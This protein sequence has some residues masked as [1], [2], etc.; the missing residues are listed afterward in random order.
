[1]CITERQLC[2]VPDAGCAAFG[3]APHPGDGG[4]EDAM[5]RTTARGGRD[6]GPGAGVPRAGGSARAALAPLLAAGLTVVALL[7]A[8]LAEAPAARAAPSPGDTWI[9]ELAVEGGDDTNVVA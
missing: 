6:R 4:G 7:G 8:G 5:T 9:A 3:A 2:A 1:M